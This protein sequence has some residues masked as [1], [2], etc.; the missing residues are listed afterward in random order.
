MAKAGAAVRSD[1]AVRPST[2]AVFGVP[3][4]PLTMRQTVDEVAA[5]V[6][7]GGP[8]QHVALNAAKVVAL[9]DD[10]TLR[11]IVRGCTLVSA[12]GQAVV[13]AARRL[14]VP[15]P[16]RVAGIDL[17]DRLLA[18]AAREGWSVYFL[19]ATP[20]VVRRV[21]ALESERHPGLVVAGYR[22][23]YWAPDQEDAVVAQVAATRPTLLLVAMPSPRK[24]Q[25][26][27]RHLADLATTFAMGVGG[28]F[29]VV[30]GVT[31]RA[32]RWMQ[33]TGLE[34]AYRLL[35]EP[36]RMLRR[37]LVGNTRFLRLTVRELAT[38]RVGRR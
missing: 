31:R 32:P 25:F 16:E 35:Q 13:W 27:A 30:A 19:G 17:M 18:R 14:G 38:A 3:L 20:E 21:V 28:S 24:E 11:E 33:R 29:D 12:D 36:R 15:V 10:A 23:G 37:Y 5:L 34:W 1:A 4:H 7:T 26:L 9:H 22:D 6:A 8:H 2:A